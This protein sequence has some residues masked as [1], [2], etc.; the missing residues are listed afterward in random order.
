MTIDENTKI[1]L[2][3][4]L[5]K[6]LDKKLS[7]LEKRNKEEI[8]NLSLLYQ[9][10]KKSF[11]DLKENSSK[12]NRQLHLIKNKYED[13]KRNKNISKLNDMNSNN[14]FDVN[15][16][17]NY[18]KNENLKL[19]HLAKSEK[20]KNVK[21]KFIELDLKT[22]KNNDLLLEEKM[23]NIQKSIKDLR[24]KFKSTKNIKK[25]LFQ[26]NF[27]TAESTPKKKI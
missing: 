11:R 21:K 9:E 23:N 17:S 18:I 4:L 13:E 6:K 20:K 2:N 25:N 15:I 26:K 14:N 27:F 10:S 16:F 7:K 1:L 24:T 12:V 5:K 19:S 8:S 22:S 3:D